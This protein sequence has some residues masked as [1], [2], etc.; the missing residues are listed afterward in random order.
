[1]KCGNNLKQIGLA[2]HN[3]EQTH[4]VF[5][6]GYVSNFDASENDT[7]PD[8]ANHARYGIAIFA[9]PGMPEAVPHDARLF[10]IAPTVLTALG[11]PVPDDMQGRSLV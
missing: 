9:G 2:L 8:D 7:G 10:D 5:P 11:L 4:K 3:Y 1:M 6:P